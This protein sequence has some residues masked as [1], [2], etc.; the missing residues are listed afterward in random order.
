M[1]NYYRNL[2]IIAVICT[3]LCL[4][5][6]IIFCAL[7]IAYGAFI[8]ALLGF[9][10]ATEA[11]EKYEQYREWKALDTYCDGAA[12]TLTGPTTAYAVCK[13]CKGDKCE[14]PKCKYSVINFDEAGEI[15]YFTCGREEDNNAS[16]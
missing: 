8:T 6:S 14:F 3:L 15:D 7:S 9:L 12:T 13:A 11:T 5:L 1:T 4:A 16:K 10:F 2:C